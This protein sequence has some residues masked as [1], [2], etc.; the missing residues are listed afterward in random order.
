MARLVSLAG[1]VSA[2]AVWF[3]TAPALADTYPISGTVFNNNVYTQT[4]DAQPTSQTSSFFS[5]GAVQTNPGMYVD[6]TAT[7]PGGTVL[8]LPAN[9]AAGFNQNYPTSFGFGNYTINASNGTTSATSVVPYNIDYFTSAIP[10]LTNFSSLTGLDPTK[11]ATVG[12]N[13]FMPNPGAS[14]G[15]T[16]FT[17]YNSAGV[18]LTD[19]FL[20]PATTSIFIP[21]SSLSANTQYSFELDF[22]DRLDGAD[23][24]NQNFTE[25]G[26]DVRTDGAF[27]TGV[28]AVPEPSTWAMM[29]LGFAGIGFLAYRQK[30]RLA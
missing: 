3:S 7:T 4:S 24:Q 14:E 5:L 30:S 16:F 1:S 22:S 21:A 18:V 12:F 23:S 26:F 10:Y 8:T 29:M 28:G 11:D 13:S 25:Q 6:A 27:V 17:I 15:Y 9:G 19:G 2:L 20:S